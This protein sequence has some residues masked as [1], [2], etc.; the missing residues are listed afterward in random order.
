M[1]SPNNGNASDLTRPARGE[2]A[3]PAGVPEARP[4]RTFAQ[5]Q[6]KDTPEPTPAPIEPEP[7]PPV[8]IDPVTGVPKARPLRRFDQVIWKK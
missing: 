4:L 7:V 6:W 1:T 8:E 2:A 5:Y 3:Q